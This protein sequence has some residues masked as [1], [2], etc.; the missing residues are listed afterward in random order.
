MIKFYISEKHPWLTNK[1]FCFVTSWFVLL[2]L[3][4][5]LLM[6]ISHLLQHFVV[7]LMKN[8]ILSFGTDTSISGI[9]NASKAKSRG[10]AFIW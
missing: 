8:K 1:M 6:I 3:E 4:P 2:L 9:N 7:L 5:A 10:R